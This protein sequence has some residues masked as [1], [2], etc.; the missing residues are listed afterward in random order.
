M[1]QHAHEQTYDIHKAAGIIIVDRKVIAT[2]TVGQD[3]YIQPGGKLDPGESE[4][5]ALHRE[6]LEEL[7]I[8]FADEDTEKIDDFY[9]DA[10]GK[11]GK[12]LKLAA[13]LITRYQGDMAP[14]SEI[15]EIRAFGSHL[16]DDVQIGSIFVTEIIPYLKSR[17]LI[18]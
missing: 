13:Y 3:I 1:S 11:P 9:A 14:A 8:T 15:E 12:R 17:D 2:R 5:D 10:A 7:G 4:L 6:L 18:D 16:P